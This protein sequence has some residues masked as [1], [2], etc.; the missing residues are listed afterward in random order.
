[1]LGNPLL[2][3]F[4]WGQSVVTSHLL[5]VAEVQPDK[6]ELLW[7]GEL[8]ATHNNS[9][10]LPIRHEQI[11][12]GHHPFDA[13]SN[14]SMPKESDSIKTKLTGNRQVRGSQPCKGKCE[15]NTT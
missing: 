10:K 2:P 5:R 3:S 12:N 15:F 8:F 14:L 9:N 4:M 13:N 6:D 7:E 11:R 1:L